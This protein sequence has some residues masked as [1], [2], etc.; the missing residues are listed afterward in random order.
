MTIREQLIGT[1]QLISQHTEFPDGNI[2]ATRGENP[3]GLLMYDAQGNMSVQL[4]RTDEKSGQHFDL[5]EAA[6]FI[7]EYHAYFGTYSVHED[8]GEVHHHIIGA[9]FPDY[10]GTCQIRPFTL[11]GDTLTL[12]VFAT[13]DTIR[14]LVWQKLE[15]RI[16]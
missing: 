1:W 9:A 3:S 8:I 11:E 15:G 2:Q 16:T 6:T 14:I 5:R 7:Q 13:D 4:M 12:R 10:R